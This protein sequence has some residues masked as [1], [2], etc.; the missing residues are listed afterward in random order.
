MENLVP[1]LS[2]N[3]HEILQSVR[4]TMQVTLSGLKESRMSLNHSL[5]SLPLHPYERLKHQYLHCKG[6]SAQCIEDIEE[7]EDFNV[8]TAS[9]ALTS[10]SERFNDETLNRLQTIALSADAV[11]QNHIASPFAALSGSEYILDEQRM[12]K[13][14]MFLEMVRSIPLAAIEKN[15]TQIAQKLLTQYIKAYS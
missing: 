7:P 13:H 6:L 1:S 4:D 9:S 12:S 14:L 15:P 10:I 2:A 5:T 3:I 8:Y 11:H